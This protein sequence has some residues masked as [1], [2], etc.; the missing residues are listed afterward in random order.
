[1]EPALS[2]DGPVPSLVR[3]CGH[4]SLPD[5]PVRAC[6]LRVKCASTM[7]ERRATARGTGLDPQTF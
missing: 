4:L 1:M 5:P 7:L 2:H 3:G 6:A